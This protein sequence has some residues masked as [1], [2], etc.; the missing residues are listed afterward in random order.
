MIQ[1]INSVC[2]NCMLY[3]QI[4]HYVIYV[5][6]VLKQKPHDK[7]ERQGNDLLTEVKIS[8]TEALCGF[9]KILVTHLDGRGLLVDHSPGQVIKPG[10]IRCI[11]NEGMP[12]Y[13]HPYDKGDL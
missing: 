4:Y 2:H 8:I 13:K 11:P 9:S 6:L 7:F 12:R 3:K 5:I 1:R 10:T